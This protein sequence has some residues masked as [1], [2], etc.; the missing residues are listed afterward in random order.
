[1]R[2]KHEVLEMGVIQ[3]FLNCG[4]RDEGVL[5]KFRLLKIQ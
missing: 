3:Y 4:I 2:R 1:M 5:F